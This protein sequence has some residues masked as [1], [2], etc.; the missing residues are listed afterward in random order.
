M[1]II[2]NL[3]KLLISNY[4]NKMACE[5]NWENKHCNK[6]MKVL[7]IIAGISIIVCGILRLIFLS[8]YFSSNKFLY[9]ALS[10]YLV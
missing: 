2:S 7:N 6:I 1:N 3:Y 4:D 10:A 8:Q 5:C 9:S